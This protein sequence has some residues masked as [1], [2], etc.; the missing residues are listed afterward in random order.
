[1]PSEREIKKLLSRLDVCKIDLGD[2][3]EQET[4]TLK[5]NN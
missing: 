1:M 3:E 5:N 2:N 4:L